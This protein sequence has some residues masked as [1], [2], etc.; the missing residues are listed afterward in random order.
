MKIDLLI[1][2]LSGFFGSIA[3]YLVYVYFGPRDATS[4]PWGT[5]VVNV[6]GC[7][8]IG[9]VGALIER[10][11]PYH[12]HIYLVGSVGFLGAFTTFSAFG[13]ETMSLLRNQQMLLGLI[14]IGAN[15][16]FGFSAVLIGRLLATQW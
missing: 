11:V 16:V 6:T 4:F 1:I 7:L 14:N 3:R 8:L 10:S 5:F 2:G 12:R 15:L 13:L 9:I